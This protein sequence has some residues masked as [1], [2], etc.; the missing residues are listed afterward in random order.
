MNLDQIK[1][2]H[3]IPY[4]HHD[5]AWC[6]TRKW[7]I[8]RYIRAFE[9]TLDLM[10]EDKELTLCVDNI[11]HSMREFVRYCPNR[12]EEFAEYVRLGRI[13]V[14]NGGM[15]L[16]RPALFDGELYIRN[17][18]DG[19]REF[20]RLFGLKAG[21]IKTFWNA[22][23]APGHS[24]MPQIMSQLG[25][26][27]Y[28]FKRP[29]GTL[30]KSGVPEVFL[31]QGLDGSS[32]I[33]DR[34][35]YSIG[36][37]ETFDELKEE[38]WPRL[39]DKFIEE[40]LKY[41]LGRINTDEIT[42][43]FGGDDRLPQCNAGDRPIN[44][45][46][47]MS[48][49]NSHEPSKMV[50]STPDRFLAAIEKKE[51]PVWQ[52]VLDA[53]ELSFNAPFRADRSLWRARFEAERKI[54]LC[55]RLGCIIDA[56]GR[57]MVDSTVTDNL[58][59]RTYE[60]AGHAMQ[61]LLEEDYTPILNGAYATID[62]ADEEIKK[63][64]DQIATLSGEGF[65]RRH[66]LINASSIEYQ[67]LAELHITSEE[68][69][70][71]LRLTDSKGHE[72]PWQLTRIYEYG[73]L[74]PGQY[75]EV[76]VVCPVTIPANGYETIH[77]HFDG[78]RMPDIQI[79]Q[80]PDI[81]KVNWGKLSVQV[82]NGLITRIYHDD[83]VIFEGDTLLKL[84]FVTTAPTPSW[85]TDFERLDDSELVVESSQTVLNGP[86][87]WE[88]KCCGHIMNSPVT[89][90]TVIEQNDPEIH[91]ALSL[92]NREKEGYFI[93]DFPCEADGKFVAG[94]PF[95]E[96]ER[97]PSKI[98]YPIREKGK[99]MNFLDFERGWNGQIWANGYLRMKLGGID[100]A[101]MQGDCDIYYQH[102]KGT[103]CASLLL[104][105]SIDIESRTDRWVRKMSEDTSGAGTQHFNFGFALAGQDC[106]TVFGNAVERFRLPVMDVDRFCLET[107]KMPERFGLFTI[108]G[109]SLR[110]TTVHNEGSSCIIRCY[111]SCGRE[112]KASIRFANRLANA[113]FCNLL[114]EPIDKPLCQN[115]NTLCFDVRPW[116]IMT[117]RIEYMD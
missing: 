107:G 26:K 64:A 50:M 2:I 71:G 23:A 83:S 104:M 9:K 89:L 97:D 69:V 96:E 32:I 55:E 17:A 88:F 46:G 101:I 116:E 47:L 67:G 61:F 62:L 14:A 6:N 11:L 38:N 60:F 52:G 54:L 105:K 8:W 51:L 3:L 30:D 90:T 82:E 10:K 94:I 56:M 35:P 109:A 110:A 115:E 40:H 114:K 13:C 112:G 12:M 106:K 53:C 20:C 117:L 18:A 5:Y 44:I 29:E 77:I 19:E 113:S 7:H 37:G 100:A 21:T 42:A 41:R 1:T 15:A 84:R 111:E 108:A 98:Y 72:L 92:D 22:D 43:P 78:A 79:D 24:Q 59:Q 63:R 25:Y 66:V 49:W 48:F 39:R 57:G 36:W 76:R 70:N 80:K 75:T 31:W 4:Y 102:I 28:R 81:Q 68:Q 95:G 99:E 86:M 45:Y 27:M 85:Y 87:R 93:A 65:D 73:R 91:F 74:R 58:W 16:V 33:V 103:Q 34:V